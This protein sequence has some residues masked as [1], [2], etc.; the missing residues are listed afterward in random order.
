MKTI[1]QKSR[2]SRRGFTLLEVLLVLAIIGVIAALAVPNLIGQQQEAMVDATKVKIK[3]FEDVIKRYA[4]SHDGRYPEGS[5]DTVVAMLMSPEEDKNGRTKQAMLEELP[6]DAWD[7]PL[8]YEFPPS[9]NRPT[10]A[11][12]PAIWSVGP[13]GQEGTDDDITNWN[14]EL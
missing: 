13:D 5:Q 4:V 10:P 8:L 9:G 2:Q 7:N 11:G 1:R 3:G 12:K 6:T 14:Q